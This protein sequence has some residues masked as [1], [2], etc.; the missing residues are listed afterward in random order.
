M[1]EVKRPQ[2]SLIYFY[3]IMLMLMLVFNSL[4]APMLSKQE[5]KEVDYGTFMTMTENKQIKSVQI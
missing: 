5:I 1:N 4:I 3:V 2:K